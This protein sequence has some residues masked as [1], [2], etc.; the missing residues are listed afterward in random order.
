M[1]KGNITH[2]CVEYEN[3]LRE[4]L[5]QISKLKNY[6]FKNEIEM[7]TFKTD[8]NK[9]YTNLNSKLIFNCLLDSSIFML[10]KWDS[11]YISQKGNSEFIVGSNRQTD[12]FLLLNNN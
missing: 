6:E 11:N 5:N 4:V 2:S 9:K 8:L 1:K 7:I 3:M 10:F 12:I